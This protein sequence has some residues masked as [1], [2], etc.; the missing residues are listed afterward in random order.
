MFAGKGFSARLR[1]AW[2]SFPLDKGATLQPL[3]TGILDACGRGRVAQLQY[4]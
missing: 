1:V 4:R 2:V 3:H